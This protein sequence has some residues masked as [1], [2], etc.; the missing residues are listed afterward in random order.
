MEEDSIP[1][2]YTYDFIHIEETAQEKELR[3]SYNWRITPGGLVENG[4]HL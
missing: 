3:L 1:K 4:Q 2:L